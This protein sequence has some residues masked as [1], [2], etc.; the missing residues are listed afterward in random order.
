MVEMDFRDDDVPGPHPSLLIIYL[1]EKKALP[2]KSSICRPIALSNE[3]IP[4]ARVEKASNLELSG[5]QRQAI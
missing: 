2:W 5:L 4:D 3:G 1:L